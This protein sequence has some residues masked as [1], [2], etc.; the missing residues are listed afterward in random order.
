MSEMTS[1]LFG[2]RSF[3]WLREPLKNLIGI[4]DVVAEGSLA[5]E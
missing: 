5:P 1:H 2:I 3:I 4:E